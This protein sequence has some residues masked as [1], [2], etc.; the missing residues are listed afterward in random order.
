MRL[1]KDSLG[2]INVPEEA[3]Y[4][5]QSTRSK[6]NFS[7]MG[8]PLPIEMIHGVV[9]LKWACAEANQKLGLLSEGSRRRL[10]GRI[11]GRCLPGGIRHLL[12]H[13]RQ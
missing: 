12:Q 2:E 4:G 10:Y 3:Y 11:C 5:A 1:E 13:E 8:E 6:E 9:R 7:S